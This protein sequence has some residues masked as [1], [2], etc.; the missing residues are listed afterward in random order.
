MSQQFCGK[1]QV[2]EFFSSPTISLGIPGEVKDGLGPQIVLQ[3][4]E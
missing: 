4:R 1:N 3:V 2:K